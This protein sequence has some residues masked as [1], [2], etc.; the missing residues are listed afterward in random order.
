MKKVKATLWNY[1]NIRP[2]TYNSSKSNLFIKKIIAQ[3]LLQFMLNNMLCLCIQILL[4]F[5]KRMFVKYIQIL[6]IIN[7]KLKFLLFDVNCKDTFGML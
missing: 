3:L 1:F 4:Y 6:E 5:G 7:C 2:W